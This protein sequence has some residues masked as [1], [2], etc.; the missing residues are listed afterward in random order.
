MPFI[1]SAA[2]RSDPAS[3][4]D[5]RGFKLLFY[6]LSIAMVPYLA[7][8][9]NDT[10]LPE[11]YTP[12]LQLGVAL[13]MATLL[14]QLLDPAREPVRNP[15][16][17]P[18][19]LELLLA[20]AS[21]ALGIDD[22]A[23][24]SKDRARAATMSYLDPFGFLLCRRRDVTIGVQESIRTRPAIVAAITSGDDSCKANQG[25]SASPLGA[26]LISAAQAHPNR[27]D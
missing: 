1:V 27:F 8:R 11:T 12:A 4:L 6:E 26:R 20:H 5:R 9:A 2:S 14:I 18:T 22:A 21:L 17:G 25:L 23:Q 7:T 13:I 16:F 19:P 15:I 3:Q 10:I 24:P